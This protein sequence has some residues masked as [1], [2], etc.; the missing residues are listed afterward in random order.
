M[1]VIH[2][3]IV[4][5]ETF[6]GKDGKPSRRVIQVLETLGKM[7]ALVNV[8]DMSQGEEFKEGQ[9]VEL[10]VSPGGYVSRSGAVE[11]TYTY[12][13]RKDAPVMKGASNAASLPKNG[14]ANASAPF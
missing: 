8:A 13:G 1:P 9:R 6:P 10:P 2:G 11:I 7:A 14:A 12:W 5:M 3:Q 4:N